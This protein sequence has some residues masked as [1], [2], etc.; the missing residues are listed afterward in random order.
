[1]RLQDASGND[2]TCKPLREILQEIE[3]SGHV[4]FELAGRC[5]ERPASVCQGNEDDRQGNL[6]GPV[7]PVE[8]CLVL[9]QQDTGLLGS[10]GMLNQLVGW[11]AIDL[12]S[13]I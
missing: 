12:L 3:K 11:V 5:H 4:E 1:M 6:E 13:I 9:P 2:G 8:I 10:K 7:T